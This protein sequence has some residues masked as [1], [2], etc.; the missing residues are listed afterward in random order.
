MDYEAAT[1]RPCKAD[2]PDGVTY[3]PSVGDGMP[4]SL[5]S[6]IWSVQSVPRQA[7]EMSWGRPIDPFGCMPIKKL[8]LHNIFDFISR[9]RW[10][11]SDAW[12]THQTSTRKIRAFRPRNGGLSS[13]FALS[14]SSH[15]WCLVNSS[16]LHQRQCFGTRRKSTVFTA[17]PARMGS[18]CR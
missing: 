8:N 13:G 12:L 15:R 18:P 3:C 17:S 4:S 1:L 10:V 14:S 16:H 5:S 7:G 6:L 9:F 11:S 2:M